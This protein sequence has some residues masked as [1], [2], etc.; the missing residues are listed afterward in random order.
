[1]KLNIANPHDKTF[2]SGP[3]AGA[4]VF[5]FGAYG[6]TWVLVY[7]NGVDSALEVAADWLK[8]NA[9]GHFVEPDYPDVD[10]TTLSSAEADAL[11]ECAEVDLTYTEAGWIPSWEWHVTG[12][13][14][15]VEVRDV[16]RVVQ[17]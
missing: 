15:P 2:V 9:P 4:F 17:A 14:T 10:W 7:A 13:H 11:R 16:A 8:D 6:S 3:E 1:M 5:T 12:P